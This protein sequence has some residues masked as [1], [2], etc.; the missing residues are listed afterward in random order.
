MPL[1]LQPK[2]AVIQAILFA[3]TLQAL[4]LLAYAVYGDRLSF[5]GGD[6]VGALLFVWVVEIP[7]AIIAEAV[8]RGWP[9]WAVLAA[10]MLLSS[11]IWA[12]AAFGVLR[13]RARR[14]ARPAV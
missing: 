2:S 1:R 7:G 9:D 6:A 14:S 10:V 3:A 11:L 12:G 5:H 13:M 4:V 8:P